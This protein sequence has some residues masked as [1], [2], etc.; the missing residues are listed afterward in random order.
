MVGK[1]WGLEPEAAGHTVCRVRTHRERNAGPSSFSPLFS[2]Q[3]PSP[4]NV[5]A[6]IQGRAS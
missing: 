3:D 5:T 4:W 6:S 2:A 1:A